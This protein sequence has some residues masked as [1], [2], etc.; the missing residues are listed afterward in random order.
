MGDDNKQS[1][2]GSRTGKERR[3][4]IDTRSDEKKQRIG[5]RRSKADRRSGK[6]SRVKSANKSQSPDRTRGD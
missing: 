4:G 2:V 3:S 6:D 1:V 5:E